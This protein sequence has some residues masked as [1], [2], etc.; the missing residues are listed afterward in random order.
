MEKGT[1]G[2]KA[3]KVERV[4]GVERVVEEKLVI[5]VTEETVVTKAN[6]GPRGSKAYVDSRGQPGFVVKKVPKAKWEKKVPRVTRDLKVLVE[7]P[8]PN[9]SQVHQDLL[10]HQVQKVQKDL[11]VD[12][13]DVTARPASNSTGQSS[14]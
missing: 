10:V 2:R 4:I 12:V 6:E 7:N 5:K 1:A 11:T 9:V 3:Q 13:V 8:I 14:R